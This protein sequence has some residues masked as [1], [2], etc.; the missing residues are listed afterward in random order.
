SQSWG[1]FA[2]IVAIYALLGPLVGAIGVT[3]LFTVYA[4]GVEIAIGNFEDIARRFVGGMVAG[5]I[6]SVIIAYAYGIVSA[7]GVG[8]VVAFGTG[9]RVGFHGEHHWLPRSHSGC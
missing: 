9:A 4:V 5:T 1:R 3:G 2:G 7:A 8:L 6:F